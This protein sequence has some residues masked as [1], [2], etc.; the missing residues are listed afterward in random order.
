MNAF[1]AEDAD[2]GVNGRQ[3]IGH[4]DVGRSVGF[5]FKTISSSQ[6]FACLQNRLSG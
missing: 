3:R 5:A 2:R 1:T 4:W 6:I